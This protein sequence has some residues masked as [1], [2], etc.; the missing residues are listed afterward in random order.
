MSDNNREEYDINDTVDFFAG[1]GSS[2]EGKSED[3]R[4]DGGMSTEKDSELD[5]FLD[6][7]DDAP[8]SDCKESVEDKNTNISTRIPNRF[9]DI[10]KLLGKKKVKFGLLGLGMLVLSCGVC[11][12]LVLGRQDKKVESEVVIPKEKY[13]SDEL[14]TQEDVDLDTGVLGWCNAFLCKDF[15]S[16]DEIANVSGYGIMGFD[17]Y[18]NADVV[19]N[20]VYN[21]MY[22]K[23]A[24]SVQSIEVVNKTESSNGDAVYSLKVSYIPY[25]TIETLDL[26]LSGYEKICEGYVAGTVTKDEFKAG[27]E[28][29]FDTWFRDCF[30]PESS[31]YA[32]TF[33]LAEKKTSTGAYIVPNTTGFVTKLL[34]ETNVQS[35]ELAFENNVTSQL[36]VV[37]GDY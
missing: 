26:D 21:I 25:K 27:L 5:D 34:R 12:S 3:K 30:A 2:I 13:L 37:L 33:D 7:F 10:G 6:L 8:S 1:M 32:F 11:F 24:D 35:V 18:T 20:T 14:I 22:E 15:E 28:G 31:E 17:D 19:S 4:A 9:S 23:L 16:C 29:C 36:D